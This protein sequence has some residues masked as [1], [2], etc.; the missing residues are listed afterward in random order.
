MDFEYHYTPEQQEFRKEVRT[1]LEENWPKDMER[2][3][4]YKH[5]SADTWRR[6]KSFRQDLGTQGWRIRGD[7]S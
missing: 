3:Q 2:G 1:W 4:D 7:T 5:T 6:L